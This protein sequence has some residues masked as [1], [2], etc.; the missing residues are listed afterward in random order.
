MTSTYVLI[1]LLRHR[2]VVTHM[3]DDEVLGST[4]PANHPQTL[5]AEVFKAGEAPEVAIEAT[6][7]PTRDVAIPLIASI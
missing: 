2:S 4:R 5:V 6:Y 7:A 3:A 1:D